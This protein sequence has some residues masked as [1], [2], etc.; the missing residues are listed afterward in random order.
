MI[1]REMLGRW[2][3]GDQRMIKAMEEQ[4]RLVVTSAQGL[5][6]TAQATDRI[7]AASVIVLASNAAFSNERVLQL[8]K[9]LVGEDLDGKVTIQTSDVVPTVTGGFR[10]TMTAAGDSQFLVPFNGT[11]ATIANT[12]TLSNKTLASPKMS[13]LSNYADDTAAAAGGVVVGQ[14]Y[15]TGSVIKVRVA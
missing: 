10:V 2:F 9:G 15:R 1:T 14:T 7:E 8:G 4:Q 11:L 13:G 6:T 12:E 3:K 5:Q